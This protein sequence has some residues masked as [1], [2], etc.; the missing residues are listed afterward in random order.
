M[1]QPLPDFCIEKPRLLEGIIILSLLV[2]IRLHLSQ[3]VWLPLVKLLNLLVY[4][5]CLFVV[6][7]FGIIQ[8]CEVFL[9]ACFLNWSRVLGIPRLSSQFANN[10]ICFLHQWMLLIINN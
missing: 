1:V 4:L 2:L 9:Q 5:Q 6:G 8:H 7:L 10:L 3:E